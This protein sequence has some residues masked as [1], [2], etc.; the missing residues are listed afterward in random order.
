MQNNR[1]TDAS[2]REFLSRVGQAGVL[3][4]GAMLLKDGMAPARAQA[5]ANAAKPNILFIVVDEERDWA[6]L[7]K[8]F[9][10][11]GNFPARNWIRSVGVRFTNY[12]VHTSPCSPSRSTLYTGKHTDSTG[13]FDN[14]ITGWQDDMKS[15]IPTIGGMLRSNGYRTAYRGKWHLQAAP[16]DLTRYGFDD[17][18]R[19]DFD[20]IKGMEGN[21]MD[22]DIASTAA[23]FISNAAT[24]TSSPWFLAV[25][26]INPHD[27]AAFPTYYNGDCTTASVEGLPGFSSLLT[28]SDV[29]ANYNDDLSSKPGAHNYWRNF[30]NNFKGSVTYTDKSVW[31]RLL[32]HYIFFMRQV[33]ANILTV[34]NALS[35]SGQL[36]N[37]V[38]VFTSD[39]G[40]LGGAHGLRS[41]GPTVYKEQYKVPL[42]VVDPRLPHDG[43]TYKHRGVETKAF[44]GGVDL[45]PLMLRLA[46]PSLG[47]ST[48]GLVGA[49]I[50]NK[51]LA[52][53]DPSTVT[54][55]AARDAILFTY[56]A[57]QG[58]PVSGSSSPLQ[59]GQGFIRG[60]LGYDYRGNMVKYARYSEPNH[61]NDSISRMQWEL[62]DYPVDGDAELKNK[63]T[64]YYPPSPYKKVRDD[65][66]SKLN[67]LIT[68]E[69]VNSNASG[70]VT[71]P[72]TYPSVGC[73]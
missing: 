9:D 60:I 34:L 56:D 14:V 32:N 72:P 33:D 25:N 58:A 7:P 19:G 37:T 50:Y 63:L 45:V 48:Y 22:V 42:V 15:S 73:K 21:E 12:H 51:V 11:A 39:H 20:D 36:E 53:N 18:I 31:A 62:Y 27:I 28:T 43:V 23:D 44:M 30:Y 3:T 61:V 2:R 29:P 49:D 71:P 24:D 65:M 66:N 59:Y 13:I 5:G 69:M 52:V 40:E 16:L 54:E 55:K 47:A 4:A 70:L 67:A 1:R 57:R 8:T 35:T 6:W 68:K 38:I 64:S 41:K 46:D 10:F 26:L 17:W